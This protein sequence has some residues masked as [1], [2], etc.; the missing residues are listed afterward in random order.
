MAVK[1]ILIAPDPRLKRVASAVEK[2]DDSVR[3]LITDMFDT[4]RATGNG[5]ALASTQIGDLRRV[6]VFDLGEHNPDPSVKMP[7]AMVN[8]E[9]TALD[10]AEWQV[11][12]EGCLSVPNL[13][14]SVER[15]FKV[16]V[17]YLDEQGDKQEITVG[18]NWLASCIQHEI[19]HLD[20]ILFPEKLS[21][22][23]QMRAWKKYQKLRKQGAQI[24]YKV[25]E[26]DS[27]IL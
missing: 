7:L 11:V 26:S 27:H 20:G 14:M 8:P 12:E 15:P 19:N 10:D 18:G 5:V 17:Q 24:N 13:Y 21:R 9:I 25:E 6:V 23:Q 22:V 2:V 3:Q 1:P 4:L 16:T